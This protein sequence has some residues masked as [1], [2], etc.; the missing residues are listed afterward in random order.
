MLTI[1]EIKKLGM[2]ARI[3][4]SEE[5]LN[6]LQGDLSAVL[7]YVKDLQSIDVTG[8][9]ELSQVTGLENVYRV[10]HP[11]VAENHADIFAN[12]PA[13][14]DDFYKVKTIL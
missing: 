13:M 11:I 9:T 2:L 7:E 10:D 6:R 14:K 12:A 5:D 3:E 8:V 1:E 4:L